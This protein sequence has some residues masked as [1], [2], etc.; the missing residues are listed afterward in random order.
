MADGYRY[1]KG[2]ML[3]YTSITADYTVVENDYFIGVGS[4]TAAITVTIPTALT[5]EGRIL[6]IKDVDGNATA[7]NV[8]I[9]TEGSET[10]ETASISADSGTVRLFSDGTDWHAF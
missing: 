7:N 5:D 4:T 1:S 6:V 10:V 2:M 8:T 9:A 3:P